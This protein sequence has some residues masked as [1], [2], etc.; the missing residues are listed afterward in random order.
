MCVQAGYAPGDGQVELIEIYIVAT[1][2]Q[3]LNLPV[4]GSGK[5]Y[6][7]DVIGRAGGAMIAGNPLRRCQRER[8][9]GDG[10]VDLGMIE[11]ARGVRENSRYLDGSLRGSL[12]GALFRVFSSMLF[13]VLLSH[14]RRRTQSKRY[15]E[16][17]DRST[18]QGF[19][20]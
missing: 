16:S 1:P 18:G 8:T 5:D 12:I 17:D 4:N 6:A 9:L 10:Q 13:G 7:G 14:D 2:G 15:G 3:R 20:T 11:L 19:Q